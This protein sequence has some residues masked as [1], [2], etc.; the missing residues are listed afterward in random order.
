MNYVGKPQEFLVLRKHICLKQK[1]E[2]ALGPA[3]LATG[4]IMIIRK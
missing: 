3:E 2:S 4:R 1:G